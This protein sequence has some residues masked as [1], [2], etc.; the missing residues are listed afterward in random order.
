MSNDTKTPIGAYAT[1]YYQ[2]EPENTF[3]VYFSLGEYDEENDKDSFG[4]ND[5]N[6]FFYVES[7]EDLVSLK[8]PN[9]VEDFVVI[10]YTLEYR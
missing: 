7:E 10:D 3:D 1:V 2:D 4:V 9:G 6:I 5:L 8:N